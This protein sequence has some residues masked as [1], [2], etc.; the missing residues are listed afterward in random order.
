MG[1]YE[2]LRR[3]P[4]TLCYQLHLLMSLRLIIQWDSLTFV[5]AFSNAPRQRMDTMSSFFHRGQFNGS[6]GSAL[7][8]GE[9]TICESVPVPCRK[10][11]VTSSEWEASSFSRTVPG[12]CGIF[13]SANRNQMDCEPRHCHCADDSFIPSKTP[14]P[15]VV[16]VLYFC[17]VPF[18]GNQSSKGQGKKPIF[19]K[20]N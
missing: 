3:G 14:N 1:E 5:P 17:L 13:L 4:W 2:A 19:P 12:T 8:W 7:G 9:S 15:I 10:L 20:T 6:F 16:V 11:R 18:P